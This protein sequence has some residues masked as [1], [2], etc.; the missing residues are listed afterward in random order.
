MPLMIESYAYVNGVIVPGVVV[1]L[2]LMI[3]TFVSLFVLVA[4]D[5][6]ENFVFVR[7][8][9]GVGNNRSGSLSG[10]DGLGGNVLGKSVSDDR[11]RYGRNLHKGGSR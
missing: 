9:D 6:F 1:G 4:F 10:R 8:I 7:G 5:G 3:L 2:I 11:R